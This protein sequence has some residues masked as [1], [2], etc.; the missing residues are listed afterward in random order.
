M[1]AVCWGGRAGAVHA[2]S[3]SC[4]MIQSVV[5]GHMAHG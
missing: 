4:G 2:R 1:E 3:R 5:Q